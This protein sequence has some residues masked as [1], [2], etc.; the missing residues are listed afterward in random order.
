MSGL[1]HQIME[2]CGVSQALHNSIE[3]TCV[4][5]VH[6]WVSDAVSDFLLH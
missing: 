4:A 2:R 1:D 5:V 3:E 6:H